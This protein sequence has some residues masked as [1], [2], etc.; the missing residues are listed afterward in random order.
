MFSNLISLKRHVLPDEEI[1]SA[2]FDEALQILGNGVAEQLEK[3]C[4]RRFVRE[5]G[6]QETY[7][8]DRSFFVVPVYPIETVS[9]VE[10]RGTLDDSWEDISD[11][12]RHLHESAGMIYFDSIV[13]PWMSRIRVTWD[14]GYWFDD[15]EDESGNQ[16]Q[17]STLLPDDLKLAWLQQCAFAWQQTEKLGIP[18]EGMPPADK[19]KGASGLEQIELLPTVQAT[20]KNYKSYG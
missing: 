15:T 10:L 1:G 13:G 8:A 20:L 3:A 11:R 4:R 14:G 5:T 19:S 6:A 7:T 16:P 9:A 17:G 12:M 18:L 2:D